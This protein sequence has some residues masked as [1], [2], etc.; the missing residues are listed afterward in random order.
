MC[1]LWLIFRLS[2][3]RGL[4]VFFLCVFLLFLF[5]FICWCVCVC[6]CVEYVSITVFADRFS[7]DLQRNFC[8]GACGSCMNYMYTKRF[9]L[10]LRVP[11]RLWWWRPSVYLNIV[12]AKREKLGHK[13]RMI[14]VWL[15]NFRHNV[16]GP[17]PTRTHTHTHPRINKCGAKCM[18]I[19]LIL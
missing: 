7:C 12:C 14:S 6:V 16:C 13:S 4:I 8:V 1:I 5:S 18:S 2:F 10:R 9:W 3:L 11:M 15:Q 17:H 19:P